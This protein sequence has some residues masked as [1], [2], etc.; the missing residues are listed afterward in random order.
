LE[1][2]LN[3]LNQLPRPQD[4]VTEA[5]PRRI[6]TDDW[7]IVGIDVFGFIAEQ[8]WGFKHPHDGAVLRLPVPAKCITYVDS[9][10]PQGSPIYDDPHS[11]AR[12]VER[13]SNAYVMGFPRTRREVMQEL[14]GA[15]YDNILGMHHA[16]IQPQVMTDKIMTRDVRTTDVA[17]TGS[18]TISASANVAAGVGR[19]GSSNPSTIPV[20]APAAKA[21]PKAPPPESQTPDAQFRRRRMLLREQLMENEAHVRAPE[22]IYDQVCSHSRENWPRFYL[23]CTTCGTNFHNGPDVSR[24]LRQKWLDERLAVGFTRNAAVH[25]RPMT[26]DVGPARLPDDIDL[27]RQPQASAN[28]TFQPPTWILDAEDASVDFDQRVE[29]TFL[30]RRDRALASNNTSSPWLG[31]ETAHEAM[32]K[33]PELIER[34][35]LCSMVETEWTTFPVLLPPSLRQNCVP[36]QSLA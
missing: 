16:P 32:C 36:G 21:M 31:Y 30:R 19:T 3:G 2:D 10:V 28:L 4:P 25:A 35:R 33:C 17:G 14:M 9:F 7:I 23:F 11:E 18:V 24:R 15:N 22:L 6:M 5:E 29:E 12:V 13:W 34:P 27:E 26:D 8:G 1:D 20:S